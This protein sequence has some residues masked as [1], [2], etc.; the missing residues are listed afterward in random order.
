VRGFTLVPHGIKPGWWRDKSE[1]GDLSSPRAQH[2]GIPLSASISAHAARDL[3]AH[4]RVC[5]L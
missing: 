4:W 2:H 5:I 3:I 1:L